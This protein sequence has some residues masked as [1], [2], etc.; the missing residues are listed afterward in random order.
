MIWECR[1]LTNLNISFD[2]LY[3][4]LYDKKGGGNATNMLRSPRLGITDDAE[5]L[6][7]NSKNVQ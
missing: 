3:D 1:D 5:S 7:E 4:L 6:S 2:D